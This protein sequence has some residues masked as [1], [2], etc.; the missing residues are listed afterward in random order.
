MKKEENDRPRFG[1]QHLLF[2]PPCSFFLSLFP[3]ARELGGE[4]VLIAELIT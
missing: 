4:A 3:L 1:T 2:L